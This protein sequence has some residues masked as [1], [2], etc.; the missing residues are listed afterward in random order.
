MGTSVRRVSCC[1]FADKNPLWRDV[2]NKVRAQSSRWSNRP[3]AL[4]DL[5]A[6]H[7]GAVVCQQCERSSR[8]AE[9]MRTV[10]LPHSC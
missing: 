4:A 7:L 2:T 10:H 3:L 5:R 8:T 9:T 1:E 6:K